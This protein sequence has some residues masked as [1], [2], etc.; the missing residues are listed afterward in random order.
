MEYYYKIRIKYV[1]GNSYV[2]KDYIK[3][4]TEV[5]DF[6]IWLKNKHHNNFTIMSIK[7]YYRYMRGGKF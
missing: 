6:F 2:L 3:D 7:P 1:V 5:A 4:F